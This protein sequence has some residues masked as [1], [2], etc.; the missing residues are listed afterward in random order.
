MARKDMDALLSDFAETY[1]IYNVRQFPLSY[2]ASLATGLPMNS[3]IKLL[4]SNLP[5]PYETLLLAK[6]VDEVTMFRYSFSKDAKNKR[7]RPKSIFNELV[8]LNK[9]KDNDVV[10]FDDPD[11][12]WVLR[13]RVVKGGE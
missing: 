6:M 10:I 8:N 12:F 4:F 11:D 3:R 13:N 7:N 5:V 2:I 9:K 1:H